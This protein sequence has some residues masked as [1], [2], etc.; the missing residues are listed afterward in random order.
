M[1][2]TSGALALTLLFVPGLAGRVADA[3]GCD[4]APMWARPSLADEA[5]SGRLVAVREFGNSWLAD[6]RIER[7][8]KGALGPNRVV[9]VRVDDSRRKMGRAAVGQ[10]WMLFARRE[11]KALVTSDCSGSWRVTTKAPLVDEFPPRPIG[12]VPSLFAPSL[13]VPS[14][15][16]P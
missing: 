10:R 16:T 8:W 13:P 12:P 7:S 14:P 2:L 5:F 11:G 3:C 6:V 1:R 9:S 15:P 4:P